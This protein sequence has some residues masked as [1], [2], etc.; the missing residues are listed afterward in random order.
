MGVFMWVNV[1]I[2]LA[3]AVMALGLATVYARNHREIGSPLTL[4]L[5]L[6]A[7]F[8][9]VHNGLVAY[10][11]LTMMPEFLA[12][13]EGWLLAENVLQAGGLLALLYATMR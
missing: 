4:G 13:K 11:Y 6:F 7:V 12:V 10:H 3:N 9:V 5:L 2:A 1:G 8:F